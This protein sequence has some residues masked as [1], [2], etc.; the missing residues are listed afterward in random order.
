MIPPLACPKVTHLWGAGYLHEA[1]DDRSYDVDG[2]LYCG[3][4]HA[5]CVNGRCPTTAATGERP[6][7]VCLSGSTRFIEHMAVAAWEM[8]KAGAIVLSCHLLPQWYT[9]IT[10]HLAEDQGVA[11]AMD[12]LHLRKIDMADRLHVINIGGYTG[13]STEREIAYAEARGK[14]VSYQD[15]SRTVNAMRALDGGGYA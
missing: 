1:D 6:E 15:N 5:A 10:D 11:E 7:I 13:K 8:E 3:R 12:A 2:V 14:P 9:T 4:C